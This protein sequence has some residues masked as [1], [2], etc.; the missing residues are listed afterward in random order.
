[1]SRAGRVDDEFRRFAV[2]FA[3]TLL[4][5]AYFL[6]HDLDLA[7]DAVQITMF[8]TSRHWERAKAAPEAYSR[9]VLINVC[10]E[11][12]RRRARRPQEVSASEQPSEP[13]AV[14]FTDRV[15]QRQALDQALGALLSPQREILVLRFFFDLSVAQTAE[16]LQIAEGT[17]K[18]AT[19]R[20][21]DQLRDIL[22]PSD[23]KESYVE[24]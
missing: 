19:H 5:G 24:Q 11:D 15:Q 12:W 20:G 22:S 23:T 18:S 16:L 10:R 6:L 13:P 21:L 4:R 3:P 2:A 7:Q 1:M 9:R 14:S 8:Q 17:V